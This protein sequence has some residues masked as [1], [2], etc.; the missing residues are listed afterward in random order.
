[1]PDTTATPNQPWPE[2]IVRARLAE[3]M[4]TLRRLRFPTHGA[5]PTLRSTMPEPIRSYWE[6]YNMTGARQRLGPARPAAI[7]RM[8]EALPWIYQI[9]PP[10]HRAAVCLRAIG[11]S[12]RRIADIIGGTSHET[13]RQW[14][15]AAI[16]GLVSRLNGAD[17]SR[18][19]VS[20]AD[21]VP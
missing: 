1:M 11:L 3:A 2:A 14:D 8:D 12:W 6:A 13:V 15:A 20:L 9:D 10:K 4:D 17:A 7:T 5:P 21:P 16:S 18:R 19:R